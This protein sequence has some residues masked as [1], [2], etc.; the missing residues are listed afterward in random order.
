ML[1][2]LPCRQTMQLLVVVVVVVV[3]PL[4]LLLLLQ[5]RHVLSLPHR[6]KEAGLPRPTTPSC[7]GQT[8]PRL[9]GGSSTPFRATAQHLWRELDGYLTLMTFSAKQPQLNSTFRLESENVERLSGLQARRLEP[10]IQF[11]LE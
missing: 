10:G 11:R 3:V 7:C 5:V 4:L 1:R 8:A 6:A 9:R 2:R